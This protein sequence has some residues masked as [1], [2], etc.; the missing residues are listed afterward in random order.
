MAPGIGGPARRR[1][2]RA[3]AGAG[4][5][6]G[7]LPLFGRGKKQRK[8]Q[9]Q[10]GEPRTGAGHDAGPAAA[11]AGPGPGSRS[12]EIDAQ[13][14]LR[15]PLREA[16]VP[17]E[18][19]HVFGYPRDFAEAFQV[20]EVVGAGSYG[21]VTAVTERRTGRRLASKSIPKVPQRVMPHLKAQGFDRATTA[22][23]LGKIENE[24][25][26][27]SALRGSLNVVGFCGAYEDDEDVHLVMDRCT[28]GTIFDRLQEG[29]GD[30]G[31]GLYSERQA[32]QVLKSVLQ[33]LTQCHARG[34]MYMDIKPDNFLYLDQSRRS[35]LKAIDFGLAQAFEPGGRPLTVKRGTPVYMAPEVVLQSY[36]EKADVWSAGVLGFQLLHGQLP[37][38]EDTRFLTLR[39]VWKGVLEGE[40][41]FSDAKWAGLSADARDFVRALLARNP[42]AR[43]SAR[44]ALQHPWLASPSSSSDAAKQ[45]IVQK[46]QRFGTFSLMKQIVLTRL[47]AS[48]CAVPEEAAD[49]AA[50]EAAGIFAS[51]DLDDSGSVDIDEFSEGL[52]RNGF[53][54]SGAEARQLLQAVDVDRSGGL[55]AAEVAAALTAWDRLQDDADW[56]QRC[57]CIFDEIDLDG[58]GQID[59]DELVALM[60][61]SLAGRRR[62]EARRVLR[63]VDQDGDGQVSFR[64]FMRMLTYDNGQQAL[65]TFDSRLSV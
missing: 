63:E 30:P 2:R 4:A 47:S 45:Q 9:P 61:A 55:E 36:T 31:G 1:A 65:N 35:V 41:D 54:V 46:L 64:E 24:A 39:E 7:A 48:L 37:F 57:R 19:T 16:I 18:A 33:M 27:L 34:I 58:N 21:V 60:P 13:G 32:A 14:V 40:V 23:Y 56:E 44:E 29:G 12:L 28:G 51:L 26:I 43:P 38:F 25:S 53:D 50:D 62:L 49:E 52:R 5:R 17:A 15:R 6:A 10:P 42:D 20:Q 8:Q 59:V 22:A 3:P 11:P